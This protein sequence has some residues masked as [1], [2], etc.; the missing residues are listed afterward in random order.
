MVSVFPAPP[1]ERRR[2]SSLSPHKEKVRRDQAK[3]IPVTTLNS[4]ELDDGEKK[5]ECRIYSPP[6]YEG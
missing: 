4:A 5:V 6:Y 2:R 3:T 1:S